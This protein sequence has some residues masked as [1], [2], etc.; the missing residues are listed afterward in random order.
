VRLLPL[1][2]SLCWGWC[3]LSFVHTLSF[4][5]SLYLSLSP[6][7]A[8]SVAPEGGGATLPPGFGYT[9]KYYGGVTLSA[10]VA[11]VPHT[12]SPSR[13]ADV[14]SLARMQDT[15]AALAARVRVCACNLSLSVCVCV[16]VSLPLSVG[17]I[18]SIISICLSLSH[19][20]VL[21]RMV[22]VALCRSRRT[23]PAHAVCQLAANSRCPSAPNT[24]FRLRY[25]T[26]LAQSVYPSPFDLFIFYSMSLYLSSLCSHSIGD[27]APSR[28]SSLPRSRAPSADRRRG[29]SPLR[30]AGG[31]TESD[32]DEVCWG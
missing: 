25:S 6:L 13:P 15:N 10:S 18:G 31:L 9:P 26:M 8:L 3:S 1:S 14:A 29:V 2:G 28:N 27:A 5:L 23:A 19:L 11:G 30:T 12:S 16:C 4:Y 21:T 24:G 20:L 22:V 7:T 32:M 17:L